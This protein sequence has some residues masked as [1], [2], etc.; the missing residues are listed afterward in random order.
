MF[1]DGAK[2]EHFSCF[3]SSCQLGLRPDKKVDS[4]QKLLKLAML[5]IWYKLGYSSAFMSYEK[6][7]FKTRGDQGAEYSAPRIPATKEADDCGILQ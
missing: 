2:N 3:L 1:L 4:I 7:F 6:N 5:H